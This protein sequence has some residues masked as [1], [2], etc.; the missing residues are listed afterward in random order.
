MPR[1][2]AADTS[3]ALSLLSS[4]LSGRVVEGLHIA[5]AEP[6]EGPWCWATFYVGERE[7]FEA[8]MCRSRFYPWRFHGNCFSMGMWAP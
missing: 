5:C 6:R 8:V 3:E 7:R 4:R 1:T 2:T